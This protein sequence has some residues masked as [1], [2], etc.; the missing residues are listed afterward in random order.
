[1]RKLIVICLLLFSYN[2]LFSQT[3]GSKPGLKITQLL[4]DSELL[5]RS[6]ST[7]EIMVEGNT[8]WIATSKGL[9]KTEDNG[10][11][12]T[13]YGELEE[14]EGEFTSTVK[15]N[16]GVVWTATLHIDEINGSIVGVGS[17]LRY[18]SDNGTTWNVLPQPLDQ[19][20]A[21]TITYGNNIL[22]ALP[23]TV[24]EENFIYDIGFTSDAVWIASRAAGLRKSTDMGQTWE[25]VVL[26]PDYLNEIHP[27]DDLD[28]E[29]SPQAG[30]ITNETNLNHIAFSVLAL[31]DTTILAG[32]S[33]GLNISHDG[34]VSWKKLNHQ[35]QDY[36]ISGN[37]VLNIAF[38]EFT[39]TIWAA[40]RKTTGQSE[41]WGV[42]SSTDMGE[43]WAVHLRGEICDGIDFKYIYDGNNIVDSHVM[44]AT[45]NGVFRTSSQGNT[46]IVAS[47]IK[48]DYS[49]LT[50]TTTHFRTV[51][52]Q[53][54]F[55]GSTNIW[56]GSANGLVMLNET[57]GFWAGDWRIF[58]VSQPLA[59]QNE[60]YTFPNPFHPGRD[61]S[62]T[63]FKYSTNGISAD[64]TIR[65][66]DFGMNLVR[67]VIQN[68]SR[69][70]TMES[71]PLD[72][73][74]GRDDKGRIVPNGVYMYRIDVDSNDPLYGKILVV[75]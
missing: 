35:N 22:K 47:G 29:L 24:E 51:A 43:T 12:W 4:N 57:S 63:R 32:T 58:F 69:S 62:V 15:Y 74:D 50:L 41:D 42:S 20:D 16:N 44:V 1:M 39:N 40:T 19:E 61:V 65:I 34:G 6:N 7:E 48:D 8:V 75:R 26:P 18:S 71:A 46:W 36:P 37:Q 49:N 11:T 64:V 5:P 10:N 25:R 21:T 14:F 56:L 27:G 53:Y 66:F 9:S 54:N 67:T 52:T 60:S 38:D 73:W 13:N 55:D 45:Q 68:A 2:T 72:Y 70:L 30:K 28:F 31:N 3:I 23:V 59:S 33:G 17:G